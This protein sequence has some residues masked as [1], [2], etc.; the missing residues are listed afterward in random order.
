MIAD[1]STL[2]LDYLGCTAAVTAE[3]AHLAWLQEFLSP[4]FTV[5]TRSTQHEVRYTTDPDRYKAVLARGPAPGSKK[6]PC[7]AFDQREVAY[8]VWRGDGAEMVLFDAEFRSF[9]VIGGKS[10][11]V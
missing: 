6:L 5:L 2:T 11:D 4:S 7:F 8:P 1:M 3:P 9:Y 10:A